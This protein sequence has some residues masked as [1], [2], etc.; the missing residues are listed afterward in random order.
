MISSQ[1]FASFSSL[2]CDSVCSGCTGAGPDQCKTCSSG[3]QFTEGTCTGMMLRLLTRHSVPAK[4]L[5]GFM[6]L[7]LSLH[8]ISTSALSLSPYA[9]WNTRSA[10]TAKVATCVSAL[11]VSK[12]KKTASVC[13]FCS[14][15]GTSHCLHVKLI[16]SL[17]KQTILDWFIIMEINWNEDLKC[18]S[19]LFWNTYELMMNIIPPSEEEPAEGSDSTISPH[20][21]LWCKNETG[22]PGN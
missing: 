15:V 6:L 7:F 16:Q 3:Y 22:S 19:L 13:K 11:P 5:N 21:E 18:M 17:L 4:V 9:R 2:A 14:Q 8:K 10:S 12:R 20:R 1:T